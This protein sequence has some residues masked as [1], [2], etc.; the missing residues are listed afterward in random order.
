M[1]SLRIT[2]VPTMVKFVGLQGL[3]DA[4]I[5]VTGP[6]S[7]LAMTT[8]IGRTLETNFFSKKVGATPLESLV[9]DLPETNPVSENGQAKVLEYKGQEYLKQKDGDWKPYAK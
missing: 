1:P 7:Y 5:H 9:K 4:P 2:E 3:P 6:T 8:L